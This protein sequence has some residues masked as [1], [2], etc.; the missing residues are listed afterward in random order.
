MVFSGVVVVYGR[1][2]FVVIGIGMDIEMG[3]IVG[4]LES[5]ENKFILL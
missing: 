5:V 1:G 3:K 2:F 4:F